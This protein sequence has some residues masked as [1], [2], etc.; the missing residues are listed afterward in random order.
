MIT[1]LSEIALPQDIQIGIEDGNNL[2]ADFLR[3]AGYTVYALNPKSVNRFKDRFSACA[4]KDDRFDA[5]NIAMIMLKDRGNF[6]P[7]SKSSDL[8]EDMKIHCE[9]I[10]SFVRTRT[11]LMN[12]LWAEL[13]LYFP[14][15]LGYFPG[16][17]SNVAL[18]VLKVIANPRVF[19]NATEDEFLKML[20]EIGR[21]SEKRKHALFVHLQKETIHVNSP[22]LSARSTRACFLA[23][24]ILSLN[25]SINSLD[26]I[27][28][29][30]YK[31]HS[32]ET[33]FSSL[34]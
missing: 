10:D 25:E 24:Q 32:L 19:Q 29:N 14:A 30:L 28:A 27:V 21:M 16:M 33:V 23:D 34:P 3:A 9:T 8:C 1:I 7:I 13:S 12:Q 2:L 15:F 17:K 26:E 5:F 20:Q 22:G 4:K 6:T 11:K 18:R 31:Q